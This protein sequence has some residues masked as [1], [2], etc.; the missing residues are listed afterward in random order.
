MSTIKNHNGCTQYIAKL[1]IAK[2]SQTQVDKS[3][4]MTFY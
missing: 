1:V 3:E 2:L 4:T